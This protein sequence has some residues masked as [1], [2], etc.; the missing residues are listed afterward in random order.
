M[1][2]II[3]KGKESKGEKEE[4]KNNNKMERIKKTEGERTL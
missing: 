4:R 1:G 2:K 3:I